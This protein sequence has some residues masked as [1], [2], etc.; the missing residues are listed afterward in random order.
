MISFFWD[1][2]QGTEKWKLLRKGL[3]TGSVAI[4]LLQGKGM[5]REYDFKGNDATKR[6]TLLEIASIREYE[7]VYRCKV[8]R[9]GFV[10]NS[11]YPNAGYSPDGIDGAWLLESKSFN[12]ERHEKL[13]S[14]DIPLEVK[15]QMFFGMII[16][17][18]RKARLLAYNPEIVDAPELTVIEV[19]YE[20]I[21][22]NR[23]RKLLKLD[24]KKRLEAGNVADELGLIRIEA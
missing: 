12:G 21:I 18:K 17:G 23:I 13:A 7:R 19:T 1:V 5:P 22:G 3:W 20:K 15:V 24:L 2:E 16:T 4:R 6:G 8:K 11:V 14:G 9:P 10:T